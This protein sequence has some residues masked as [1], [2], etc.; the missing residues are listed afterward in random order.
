MGKGREREGEG[1]E[2]EGERQGKGLKQRRCAPDTHLPAT[3]F[4][5]THQTVMC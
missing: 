2:R 3:L 4:K 5:E 1:E